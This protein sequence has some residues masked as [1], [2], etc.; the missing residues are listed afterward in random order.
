M[1]FSCAKRFQLSCQLLGLFLLSGLI[2]ERLF[3]QAD[4]FENNPF[5]S[6]TTPA[7]DLGVGANNA[8]GG[9]TA[10]A[11]SQQPLEEDPDPVIR[12]LRKSPP[13]SAEQFAEAFTWV[14][15]LKRWDEAQRLL[16]RLSGANFTLE[17][18]AELAR[19]AG[20][21]IWL[22]L[23]STEVE[24]SD[25]QRDLVNSVLSAPGRAAQDP[26]T[27]NGWIAK[28]NAPQ[29]QVR[30]LA[31][32]R[33]QDAGS[34]G[35]KALTDRLLA[36]SDPIPD[37]RL[38]ETLIACGRDG[39]EALRAVSVAKDPQQ[40]AKVLM[41]ISQTDSQQFSAELLGGLHHK[42]LAPQLKTKLAAAITSKFGSMPS[43]DAVRSLLGEQFRLALGAY[44]A[45]RSSKGLKDR[46]WRASSDSMSVVPVEATISQR[47]L[48]RLTQLASIIINSTLATP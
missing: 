24:L 18:Q 29:I 31:T 34:V 44:Q 33:L 28:L 17:Q 2:S 5:G 4:P 42:A 36:Q 21:A 6:Q 7:G 41:A 43:E 22:R 19:S 16:D 32:L 1:I 35:I 11:A 30:E 10:G 48:E 13:K 20:P 47:E 26:N 46:L 23:R 27:L 40:V 45:R 9:G 25:A 15:R 37:K 8:F 39:I 12:L 38:A 3:A 14:T